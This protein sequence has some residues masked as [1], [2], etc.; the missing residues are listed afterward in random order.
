MNDEVNF[1]EVFTTSMQPARMG[2]PWIGVRVNAVGAPTILAMVGPDGQFYSSWEK[3]PLAIKSQFR[4]LPDAT[5]SEQRH[6]D[7]LGKAELLDDLK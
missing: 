6:P 3:L 2:R 1:F 5:S 4:V 7:V